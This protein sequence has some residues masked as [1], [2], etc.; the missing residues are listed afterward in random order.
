MMGIV[1][2]TDRRSMSERDCGDNGCHY[3]KNRTGMRTNGGC[4]CDECP[5]CGGNLRIRGHRNECP[6]ADA[7][8]RGEF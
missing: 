7:S 3:A 4:S 5:T 1:L 8:A 6:R 2:G